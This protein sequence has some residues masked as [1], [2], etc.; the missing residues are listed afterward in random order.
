MSFVSNGF[1]YELNKES[2]YDTFGSLARAL[3]STVSKETHIFSISKI[4]FNIFKELS[5]D[6]SKINEEFFYR[7]LSQFPDVKTATSELTN[8]H[9]LISDVIFISSKGIL[10]LSF[11]EKSTVKREF[12]TVKR[13]FDFKMG[14]LFDRILKGVRERKTKDG[15]ETT[16]DY[17]PD[18]VWYVDLKI[19][20]YIKTVKSMQSAL[21]SKCSEDIVLDDIER[22]LLSFSE[23]KIGGMERG[24][25][26]FVQ[27]PNSVT[28]VSRPNQSL[29]STNKKLIKPKDMDSQLF[30]QFK[31]TYEKLNGLIL[32]A[33]ECKTWINMSGL[34]INVSAKE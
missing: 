6:L 14:L 23:L 11:S 22:T 28:K 10:D 2:F 27:Q 29:Y 24:E 17:L 15:E 12:N 34:G 5:T 32:K 19:E 25:R 4:G 16:S 18:L 30:D 31:N 3:D 21:E 8:I 33:K 1:K 9:T 13:T 26:G 7:H 20:L